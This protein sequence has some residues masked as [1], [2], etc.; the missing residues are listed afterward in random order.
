MAF[1]FYNRLSANKMIPT[2]LKTKLKPYK[3]MNIYTIVRS[4]TNVNEI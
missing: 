3:P 4:P 1:L 2:S